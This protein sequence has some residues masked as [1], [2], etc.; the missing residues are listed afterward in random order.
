MKLKTTENR[1][2]KPSEEPRKQGIKKS[3]LC[4]KKRKSFKKSTLKE[5]NT[6]RSR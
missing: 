5:E 4:L 3:K 6:P 2:W 1:R